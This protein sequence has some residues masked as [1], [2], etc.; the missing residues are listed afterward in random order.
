MFIFGGQDSKSLL[1]DVWIFSRNTNQWSQIQ[2]ET[3]TQ[4]SPRVGASICVMVRGGRRP[5]C[6][7]PLPCLPP[8]GFPRCAQEDGRR[9]LLFGGF[10]GTSSLDD[11]YVLEVDRKAWNRV[12]IVGSKTP[13]SRYCH[14]AT[15]VSGRYIFVVGGTHVDGVGE[16]RTKVP[17]LDT[18][19]LDMN[20]YSWEQLHDAVVPAALKPESTYAAL[21]IAEG[22][23][24][25]VTG[26]RRARG[27][28]TSAA[29]PPP[30]TRA[31]H[32]PLR[33][34]AQRGRGAQRGGNRGHLAAR[35]HRA[36]EAAGAQR[37]RHH[38]HPGDPLGVGGGGL[39]GA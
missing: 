36:A 23:H 30:L 34:Q 13:R 29:G 2:A 17:L 6:H 26:A 37:E 11:V 14:S 27:R 20:S 38:R 39:L 3:S 16:A 28:G 21:V 10:D 8:T 33:S 5:R 19:V 15:L 1:N 24:K 7:A 18:W 9:L 4:P 35:G 32:P 31:P 22:Q 25:I 12:K